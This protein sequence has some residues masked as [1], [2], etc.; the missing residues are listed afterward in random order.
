M[1]R[2]DHLL[3]ITVAL[4][5]ITRVSQG[6]GVFKDVE[7]PVGTGI[8]A[9]RSAPTASE[10]EIARQRSAEIDHSFYFATTTDVRRQDIIAWEGR[11][12][13]VQWVVEPSVADVYKKVLSKEFQTASE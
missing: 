11:R 4:S 2:V 5:R 3:N 7:A 6:K 13:E 8:K 10:I 12:F 9:R 1:S